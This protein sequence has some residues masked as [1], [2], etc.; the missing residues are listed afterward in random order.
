MKE[1]TEEIVSGTPPSLQWPAGILSVKIEQISG[2]EVVDPRRSGTKSTNADDDVEDEE[3][4]DLPSPYCTIIINHAKVYKTRTKMKTNNPYVRVNYLS[5][6]SKKF[7][8][9]RLS[10][11]T[12]AQNDSSNPGRPPSS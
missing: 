8:Y 10:S 5:F 1:K 3:G 4:D 6:L 12:Q 11:T 7:T 2:V 9:F